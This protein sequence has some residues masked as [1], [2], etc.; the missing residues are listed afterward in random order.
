MPAAAV[1]DS[2][3]PD[4]VRELLREIPDD[5][6]TH[7]QA[8][9]RQ[10][11]TVA[12]VLAAATSV[13][14]TYSRGGLAGHM[15]GHVSPW[16]AGAEAVEV[17]SWRQAAATALP[18]VPRDLRMRSG[19][20]TGEQPDGI[21]AQIAA[22]EAWSTAGAVGAYGSVALGTVDLSGRRLSASG[23][24]SFLHCPHHFFVT[25]VL[26]FD[27][28]E[29]EDDVDE[30]ARN[31]MG[32]LIHTVF[33]NFFRARFEAG[34]MPAPG[35][36]WTAADVAELQEHYAQV[37]A[38]AER[39]G[40]VGW[41]PGWRHESAAVSRLL[42]KFLDVDTTL[43]NGVSPVGFERKFGSEETTVVEFTT[44]GGH[45]VR[46][47]GAMDR[48]DRSDDGATVSV[49][50]YKTGSSDKFRQSFKP[51]KQR[52]KVQDLVYA[53]AAKKIDP[54]ATDVRVNFLFFPHKGK[55][56][57]VAGP[58]VDREAELGTVL[59]RLE[60]A[61]ATGAFPTTFAGDRDF[62]P[63]CKVMRRRA[64]TVTGDDD[65]QAGAGD[66]E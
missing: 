43:R 59:A 18:A 35:Q 53:V 48:Y 32:T 30:I 5:L 38:E 25:K 15:E 52:S 6:P 63:V 16:F 3:L 34:T 31:D 12:A 42:G 2:F 49:I 62:C 58:D 61:F 26:K 29:Y 44:A 14:V 28:D 33:E 21:D 41:L 50:D 51:G 47:S 13:M 37:A 55:P 27:T 10:E 17:T 36:A 23:I 54:Q 1:A 60:D 8:V 11:R 39:K 45:T 40:L 19:W 56:E 66:G 65:E 24:E 7:A 57:N 64:R 9:E 4:T 22:V 46:L 20:V